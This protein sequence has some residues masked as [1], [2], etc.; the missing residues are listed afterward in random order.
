MG[1]IEYAPN[2]GANLDF[3]FPLYHDQDPSHFQDVATTN[4][5]YINNRIHDI[6]YHYGFNEVRGNFQ[7]N[8]YERGGIGNDFFQD[9]TNQRYFGTQS[10]HNYL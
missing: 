3:D 4:L 9:G 8:N 5:F 10:L 6:M 2:G 7:A 1:P